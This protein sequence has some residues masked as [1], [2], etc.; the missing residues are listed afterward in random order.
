MSVKKLLSS[1]LCISMS[2]CASDKPIT[3]VKVPDA[4]YNASAKLKITSPG[5]L[6]NKSPILVLVS[7]F[8]IGVDLKSQALEDLNV[9]LSPSGSR[10]LLVFSNG[11]RQYVSKDD[12]NLLLTQRSYFNKR[13]RVNISD[14]V[15]NSIKDTNFVIS[16]MLVNCYG[17]TIKNENAFYSDVYCYNHERKG[18]RG[19]KSAISKPYLVYNEPYGTVKNG[20][21]LLDFYI[22]N[23]VLSANEHK[24][25]LYIDDHKVARLFTWTPYVIQNLPTGKHTI[26]LELIDP[27]GNIVKNIISKNST[28]IYVK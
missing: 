24:V 28:V 23:A 16:S 8:P 21:I 6:K 26:R 20:G 19:I 3:V 4:K 14:S 17:E 2:L 7:N 9:P 11:E 25:D 5:V 12:V 27:S 1:L 22:K 10:V 13:F 15:Y 18:I